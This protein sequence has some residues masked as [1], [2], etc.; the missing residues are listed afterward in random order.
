MV[1][2][3][4]KLAVVSYSRMRH[5]RIPGEYKR[6]IVPRETGN[7]RHIAGNVGSFTSFAPA[8]PPVGHVIWPL[9]CGNKGGKFEFKGLV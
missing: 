2:K 9:R 6:R 5:I 3:A 7:S 1:T 8:M 4:K